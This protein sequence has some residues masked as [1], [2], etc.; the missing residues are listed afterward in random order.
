MSAILYFFKLSLQKAKNIDI[1]HV[2]VHIRHISSTMCDQWLPYSTD[3]LKQNHCYLRRTFYFRLWFCLVTWIQ[4]FFE[5]LHS[6]VKGSF[7]AGAKWKKASV[8]DSCESLLYKD[9]CCGLA[10][11]IPLF[12]LLLVEQGI[13]PLQCFIVD[14]I[15][16]F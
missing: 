7:Q 3:L 5:N 12:G 8:F 15:G 10:I 14:R 6:S 11:Y 1:Q 13:L 2:S 16:S 4:L 9:Y